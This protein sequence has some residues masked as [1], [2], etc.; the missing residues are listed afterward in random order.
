MS[1]YENDYQEDEQEDD[2]YL[3]DDPEDTGEDCD[4]VDEEWL[5]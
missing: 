4:Y 3:M 1:E 2:F 5:W